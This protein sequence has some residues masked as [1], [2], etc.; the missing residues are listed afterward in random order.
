M[1]PD[2]YISQLKTFKDLLTRK[3]EH[4]EEALDRLE[5]QRE[6]RRLAIDDKDTKDATG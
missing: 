5:V 2:P 6:V 1:F 3:V 4:L